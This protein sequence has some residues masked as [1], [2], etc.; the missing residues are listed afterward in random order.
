[1]SKETILCM[2]SGG[3]DSYGCAW[4]LL[5]SDEYK[6]CNIHMHHMHV[7][8]RET[9]E[10]QE[11]QASRNFFKAVKDTTEQKI[12]YT[13]NVMDFR[14][15]NRGSFPM[16]CSLYGFVA[17]Q[18]CN[19]N[20]NISSVAFGRTKTDATPDGGMA[21]Y[22]IRGREI[23][24]AA[25]LDNRRY[26]IE[27]IYPV[28]EMTKRDIYDFLP[29]NLRSSFWSCRTPNGKEACGKCITCKEFAENGI[30]HP[31]GV[32]KPE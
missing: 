13:E 6:G 10:F 14:F 4:K 32:D 19:N 8:N 25:L 26:Q 16:D 5:S 2:F 23:F 31:I 20:K 3:L 24:T 18:I 21:R 11:A 1:M 28:G 9:R 27:Y 15:I 12:Q 17:A 22:L 29:E 7:M 30:I